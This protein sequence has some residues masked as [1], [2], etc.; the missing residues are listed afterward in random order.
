MAIQVDGTHDQSQHG[1][2]SVDISSAGQADGDGF[3]SFEVAGLAADEPTTPTGMREE[4]LLISWLIVLLRTREGG[5][6][7]YDWAYKGRECGAEQEPVKAYLSM[8]ELAIGLQDSVGQATATISQ[9]IKTISSSKEATASN[10]ASLL[11]STGSLSQSS[12]DVKEDVSD[13]VYVGCQVTDRYGKRAQFT[14]RYALRMANS[15]SAQ[16]GAP[17]GC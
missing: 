3:T 11:L 15:R 10:T 13:K 7:R 1:N 5:H 17:K 9:Y 6:I 16:L 8:G 14:L 12:D 2:G 4:V